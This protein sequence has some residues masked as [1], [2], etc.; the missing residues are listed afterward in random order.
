M[1]DNQNGTCQ[2]LVMPNSSFNKTN[3]DYITCETYCDFK[4]FTAISTLC[5]LIIVINIDFQSWNK[6]VKL[7]SCDELDKEENIIYK[8]RRT[9]NCPLVVIEDYLMNLL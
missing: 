1:S 3:G 4:F 9:Y 8:D 2:S 7:K 6:R 5:M